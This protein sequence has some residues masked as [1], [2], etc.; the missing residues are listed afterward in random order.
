MYKN[1]C[2]ILL[3]HIFNLFSLQA[4]G[5]TAVHHYSLDRNRL[6]LRQAHPLRQGQEDL[7]DSHPSAGTPT[8]YKAY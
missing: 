5:G 1:S 4:E 6:G 3:E 7:H 2:W 8:I